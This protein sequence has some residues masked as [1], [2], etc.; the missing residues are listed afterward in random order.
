M[1]VILICGNTIGCFNRQDENLSTLI[2]NEYGVSAIDYKE[3]SDKTVVTVYGD[4]LTLHNNIDI[5]KNKILMS[6]D[7]NVD[8]VLK[9]TSPLKSPDDVY[10]Q[11]LNAR[12]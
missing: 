11:V 10:L 2:L 7:G 8:I 6:Q 3:E 5:I 1:V 4:Y 9:N 12:E